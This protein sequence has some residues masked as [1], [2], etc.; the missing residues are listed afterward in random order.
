MMFRWNH[1][2]LLK[3]ALGNIKYHLPT[4]YFYASDKMIKCNCILNPVKGTQNKFCFKISGIDSA[5]TLF[6][7]HSNSLFKAGTQFLFYL[8]LCWE[9]ERVLD[10]A[11]QKKRKR[12][13]RSRRRWDAKEGT[14]QSYLSFGLK[15]GF[16]AWLA[17]VVNRQYLTVRPEFE[18]LSTILDAVGLFLV[19]Y[20]IREWSQ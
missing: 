13:E 20:W 10:D 5:L 7:V 11:L 12:V 14:Q 3:M 9:R 17:S 19:M 1:G 2:S 6:F 16:L 4:S 18:R 15:S 8:S